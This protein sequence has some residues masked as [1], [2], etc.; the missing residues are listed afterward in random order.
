M[1]AQDNK[2]KIKNIEI[3]DLAENDVNF[4]MN[5]ICI[6]ANLKSYKLMQA[7]IIMFLKDVTQN[8]Y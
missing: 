3:F 7:N 8:W 2:W 6:I 1:P 4:F 5:Q